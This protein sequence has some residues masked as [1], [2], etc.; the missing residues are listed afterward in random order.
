MRWHFRWVLM[1]YNLQLLSTCP[2]PYIGAPPSPARCWGKNRLGTKLGGD[3][4][5][6]RVCYF[7]LGKSCDLSAPKRFSKLKKNTSSKV[8]YFNL[9]NYSYSLIHLHQK[10]FS[11]LYF[12]SHPPTCLYMQEKRWWQ[13]EYMRISLCARGWFFQVVKNCWVLCQ[14]FLAFLP[15]QRCQP[16]L[17]NCWRCSNEIIVCGPTV[18]VSSSFLL[19]IRL[20]QKVFANMQKR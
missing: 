6:P 1:D 4:P 17:T 18:G 20:I 8:C 5:S 16:N 3:G 12:F 13:V 2:Y 10:H 15:K 19:I 11:I 9:P 7:Q 14:V